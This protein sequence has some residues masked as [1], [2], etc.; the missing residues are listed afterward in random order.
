MPGYFTRRG[1]IAIAVVL[2]LL[3]FA[4]TRALQEVKSCPQDVDIVITEECGKEK[5]QAIYLRCKALELLKKAQ[6]DAV[7]IQDL[8]DHAD[9]LGT[10]NKIHPKIQTTVARS[11]PAMDEGM[12]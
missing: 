9:S 11:T 8:L 12:G 3:A 1:E 2:L 5:I 6:A 10:S 7:V 4:V